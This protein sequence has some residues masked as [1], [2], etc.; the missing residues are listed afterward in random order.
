MTGRTWIGGIVGGTVLFIWASIAH[1]ATPLG[2]AGLSN[3]PNEE[4]VLEAMRVNITQ[5]GFYFF[6]GLDP[7][8]R[9]DEA[10]MKEWGV[11]AARGPTG[12]M[13]YQVRGEAGLPPR[14]LITEFVSNIAVGL[15]AAFVLSNIAGSLAFRAM[16]AGV[17]GLIA[18][19][20][21]YVSY[22]N[23]YKFPGD[24]TLAQ[25]TIQVIGFLLMGAAIAA[26][27]KKQ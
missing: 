25:M 19:T 9:N 27:A 15:L 17:I 5:P 12:I 14:L 18:G 20:D 1:M 24:Y 10:A 3:L 11:K 22:W 2:E 23:W 26:I 8:R 6:P 4:V 21:I 13:A 7:A 16:T